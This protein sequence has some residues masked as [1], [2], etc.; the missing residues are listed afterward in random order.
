[1]HQYS[2][3]VRIPLVEYENSRKWRKFQRKKVQEAM[4]RTYKQ[5]LHKNKHTIVIFE[6]S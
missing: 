5:K 2:E 6:L 1:M 3:V 4:K